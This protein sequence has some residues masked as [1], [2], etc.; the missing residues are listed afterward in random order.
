MYELFIANK[1]YSSWSLRPWILMR[2]LAIPFTERLMAFPGAPG[3]EGYKAIS[4]TGRVPALHDGEIRVWDSLGITEYLAERHPGVWPGDRVTRAWAR[5]ATAEMHAG[6]GVLR[7]RCTM[8]CGLRVRL[9][10]VP[11]ALERDLARLDEL[12]TDGLTRWGGPFLAGPKLTAV[13]AFYAPV[14]FRIQTYG[15]ELGEAAAGYARRLLAL[16]GMQQWYTSALA[17]PWREPVH[18]ADV[19][20][21]G[22]I[23]EDRRAT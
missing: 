22:V 15:L 18:E 7:D 11:A 4:P 12:W 8:N 10:D 14:A 20:K 6:F 1:N 2:E 13:D 16:P 5:S 9:H 21:T 19:Q 23:V 3:G 17:E